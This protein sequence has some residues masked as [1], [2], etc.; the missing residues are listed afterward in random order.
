[1]ALAAAAGLRVE[2]TLF[3]WWYAWGDLRGSRTW[4]RALLAPY[5]GDGRIA[6]VE[7]KNELTVKPHTVAWARAMIPFV[8]RLVGPRT[9]VT[10][11]VSG[12]SP[13]GQLA[14]LKR[15]L[16]D[17]RPDAFDVHYFGGG[18]ELALHVLTRA[19]ALAAPTPVR[20]GETGYPTTTALT[21]FGGVPRTRDAQEAAQAHFLAA[22][23]WGARAA[24]LSPPGVWLLDDLRPEAV[25]DRR[26][27]ENDPD[28]HF[29]LFRADGTAKPAAAVVR[30]A[31]SNATPVTF[32]AGFE[33]AVAAET[34]ADVPAEW[35]MQGERTTF[36]VDPAAAKEGRASARL[37]P[38]GTGS[39]SFSITP[40]DGGLRGGEHV[41]AGVWARRTTVAGRVFLVVEWVDSS[42]RTL[43]RE[44]SAPLPAGGA[45]H[46]LRAD[47]RAPRRAAYLRLALVAT[48]VTAP[49]WFDAVTFSR[50]PLAHG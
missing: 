15:G 26:V 17:V 47:G 5:A 10:L 42:G 33:R 4:A 1:M 18:G 45:W 12:R 49:V 9:S 40:P 38:E 35:S 21:G 43:G 46:R 27:S 20:V 31:F 29:G 11:S 50:P 28:L 37:S 24:G 14:R 2:L 48:R 41:R 44:A 7:L 3:D 36:A 39:G 32:N 8:R 19:R 23:A 6:A 34:G 13:V 16:G 22:L 30:S 25:P